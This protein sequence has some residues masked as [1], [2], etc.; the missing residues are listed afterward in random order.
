LSKAIIEDAKKTI[1]E[2]LGQEKADRIKWIHVDL[3]EWDAIPA[4]AKQIIADTDRLDI[5]V[6]IAARGIMTYQLNSVGV[7]L[8]MAIVS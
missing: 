3:G 8:H 2:E 6:N 7:D 1:A 5:L 4:A